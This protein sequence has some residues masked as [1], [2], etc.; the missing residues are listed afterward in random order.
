LGNL[1]ADHNLNLDI[2]APPKDIH[3]AVHQ[4]TNRVKSYAAVFLTTRSHASYTS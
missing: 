1:A 2:K 3:A 4:W